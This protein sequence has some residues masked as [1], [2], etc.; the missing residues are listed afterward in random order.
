M[1]LFFHRGALSDNA[2]MDVL[3]VFSKFGPN[4]A[5]GLGMGWPRGDHQTK[6]VKQNG[7]TPDGSPLNTF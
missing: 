7:L 1:W 3:L 5:K 2:L 6:C 4:E